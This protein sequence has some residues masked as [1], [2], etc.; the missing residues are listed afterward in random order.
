MERSVRLLGFSGFYGQ[1][2]FGCFFFNG[3]CCRWWFWGFLGGFWLLSKGQPAITG[4]LQT[5][6]AEGS[7]HALPMLFNH[8]LHRSCYSCVGPPLHRR[9]Q[10]YEL[11]HRGLIWTNVHYGLGWRHRTRFAGNTS[12]ALGGSGWAV[13]PLCSLSL[14]FSLRFGHTLCTLTP[15]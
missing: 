9:C 1:G 6:A 14:S 8:A 13:N 5:G 12:R 7:L 3:F 10:G 2:F 15:M 11:C 4:A